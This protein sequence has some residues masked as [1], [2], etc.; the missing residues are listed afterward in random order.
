MRILSKSELRSRIFVLL[1]LFSG[2]AK[3]LS[4]VKKKETTALS[5]QLVY[6]RGECV[7]LLERYNNNIDIIGNLHKQNASL[8]EKLENLARFI[9]LGYV[10]LQKIQC[11]RIDEP[12][13]L[14]QLK[15]LI[16]SCGQ[17][18]A[19]Y[20]NEIEIS[21]QI[22][23]RNRFLKNKIIIL[24][25]NIGAIKEQLKA[26]EF[27]CHRLKTENNINKAKNVVPQCLNV[28]VAYSEIKNKKQIIKE[29]DIST[30][31]KRYQDSGDSVQ[32]QG[33]DFDLSTHLEI[34]KR[35]LSDQDTLLKDL[36]IIS[37]EI[38]IV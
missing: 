4:S 32:E 33:K 30:D 23:Q 20:R 8:Q 5:S 9:N 13:T 12:T 37:Q 38:S 2:L 26:L 3:T 18:Y 36:S 27:R 28:K 24:E 34:V 25:N 29:H 21:Q 17:Y 31:E 1:T 14:A 16:E 10:E 15:K 35:L 19:D 11:E 6:A 22:K 7:D